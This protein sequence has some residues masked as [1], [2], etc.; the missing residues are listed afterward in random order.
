MRA[1]RFLTLSKEKKAGRPQRGRGIGKS[2]SYK[3]FRKKENSNRFVG[4]GKE[5]GDHL[6][7]REKKTH[8]WKGKILPSP[9]TV[10]GG[11][12]RGIEPF[13]SF[14][15]KEEKK[16]EGKGGKGCILPLTV[17]LS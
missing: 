11:K 1:T 5:E 13:D 17:F 12:G 16:G 4:G 7:S 6:P 9:R 10:G 14:F 15:E 8:D 3:N 2:L